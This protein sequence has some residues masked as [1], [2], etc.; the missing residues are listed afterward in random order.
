MYCN[1]NNR[2]IASINST[3]LIINILSENYV[4]VTVSSIISLRV[5][6]EGGSR[7][8]VDLLF[9][10]LPTHVTQLEVP[11]AGC[12][13]AVAAEERYVPRRDEADGT[14]DRVLHVPHSTFHLLQLAAADGRLMYRR[15][16]WTDRGSV[17]EGGREGGEGEGG[18][19]GESGRAGEGES[20]MSRIRRSISSN[21]PRLTAASCTDA[22]PG[23]TEGA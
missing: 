11:R 15:T 20:S 16:P 14:Y 18:G 22:P 7:E 4:N 21:W 5:G 9:D 3:R 12:A 1:I 23:Q 19:E 8:E 6:Q 10:W 13:R 17:R 2:E